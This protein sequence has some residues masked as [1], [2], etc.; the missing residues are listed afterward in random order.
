MHESHKTRN[1]HIMGHYVKLHIS[2]EIEKEK[3]SEFSRVSFF[4]CILRW[5]QSTGGSSTSQILGSMGKPHHTDE[6]LCET[7]M[8]GFTNFSF[9]AMLYT[10]RTS[11]H[12][13]PR[14]LTPIT[15]N[16]VWT[17]PCC[18]RL[19]T[20]THDGGRKFCHFFSWIKGGC[21]QKIKRC[22]RCRRILKTGI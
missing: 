7:K 13:W 22:E 3:Y 4:W 17:Q 19:L 5:W 18:F 16:D 8:S 14:Q 20:Q 2:K 10:S 21:Q 1:S 9:R 15:I 12:T 6:S 11:D